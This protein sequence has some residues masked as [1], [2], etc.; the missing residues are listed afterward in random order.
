MNFTD[1][2]IQQLYRH[3][4]MQPQ[5]I[6]KLCFQAAFGAEHLLSDPDAARR[7]F[8]AEYD[9]VAPCTGNLYES[10]SDSI[11]RI[12]LPAWKASGM[13]AEWLF[14]MFTETASVSHGS[15]ELFLQLLDEATRIISERNFAF[16]PEYWQSHLKSYLASGIHAVHHSARYR[17][18]EQP[19]YRIVKSDFIRLLPILQKAAFLAAPSA[20]TQEGDAQNCSS[21]AKVIAIDGRAAS[22][23]TTLSKLLSIVLKAG[24]VHMDDFFLPPALRTDARLEQPGGNVHYERFAMEVLPRIPDNAGFS[25]RIFDCGQMD[26]NG[27]R[28]VKASDWRIVEGSYSHHPHFGKYADLRVLSHVEADEQM[29]RILLRDGEWLAERFRSVW[30]PMEEKY[31][32]YYD[33][34]TRSDVIV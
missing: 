14:T 30:I 34:R 28:E 9:S 27:F 16:S 22:G 6:V 18:S 26:Y 4:V 29:R 8:Y 24:V 2:L 19:S 33:I 31:F 3:P 7:Y 11:C 10:I 23:K 17:E 12:S 32:E 15:T 1:H 5:D 13:P 21:K 25:Y 20:Q